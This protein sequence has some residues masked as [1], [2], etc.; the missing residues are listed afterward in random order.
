MGVFERG[1]SSVDNRLGGVNM[2]DELG[3]VSAW[4]ML[5]AMMIGVPIFLLWVV[6]RAISAVSSKVARNRPR[7]DEDWDEFKGLLGAHNGLLGAHHR[8]RIREVVLI[9]VAVVLAGPITVGWAMVSFWAVL[10]ILVEPSV[11]GLVAWAGVAASGFVLAR[12]WRLVLRTSQRR[13]VRFG[14]LEG[15]ALV[16]GVLAVVAWFMVDYRPEKIQEQGPLFLMPAMLIVYLVYLQY[17]LSRNKG[18]EKVS[19]NVMA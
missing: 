1:H 9:L 14:W 19:T 15:A 3:I 11:T 2:L 10:I 8:L 13:R 4:L 7:G 16:L 17:R 18:T 5:L 6:V 12:F